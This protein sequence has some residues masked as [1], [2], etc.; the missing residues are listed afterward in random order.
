MTALEAHPERT[1]QA[2]FDNLPIALVLIAGVSAPASGWFATARDRSAAVWFVFGALLGPLALVLL[3]LAPPGRCPTCDLAVVG[4]LARCDRCGTPFRGP[5]TEPAPLRPALRAAPSPEQAAVP[6]RA[7][8]APLVERVAGRSPTQLGMPVSSISRTRDE[9]VIARIH[10][11]AGMGDPEPAPEQ[12]LSIGVYLSGNAGLEIGATYAI[13]RVGMRLRIFGPVD[14]GQLTV[15]HEGDLAQFDVTAVDDR[16]IVAGRGGRS[17]L[18]II[19]RTIGGMRPDDLERTLRAAI[20][21]E[22]GVS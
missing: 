7:I 19:F 2:V 3:A 15:R 20:D 8:V 12:V 18:A 21:S 5:E 1:L 16:I 22:L 6:G 14:A 13:A 4:W 11:A 10:P 9:P 17:A